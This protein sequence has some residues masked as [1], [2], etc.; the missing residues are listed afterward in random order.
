MSQD[1]NGKPCLRVQAKCCATCIFR[2]DSSLNLQKLLNDVREPGRGGEMG[3]FRG[4]RVCH[5]SADAVCAGF[6]A[7]FK[8]KFQLGQLAQ[9]WNLVK[10]VDDEVNPMG[11]DNMSNKTEAKR[12]KRLA[13]QRSPEKLYTAN[14]AAQ[15]QHLVRPTEQ[16]LLHPSGL[17]KEEM[18]HAVAAANMRLEPKQHS[19]ALGT[20]PVVGYNPSW[21]AMRDVRSRSKTQPQ[22][23]VYVAPE[24]VIVI[25]ESEL[26]AAM[27]EAR[28]AGRTQMSTEQ[29]AH[30]LAQPNPVRY[31]DQKGFAKWLGK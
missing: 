2:K 11:D 9:R 29:L 23:R 7:C 31:Q 24:P 3:Y 12:A 28:V 13:A 5:Y 15:A 20:K 8:D 18:D 30:L 16:P 10:Y 19:L 6:W 27:E 4:Y 1:E 14:L 26:L 22:E 17:T 25:P 21:A